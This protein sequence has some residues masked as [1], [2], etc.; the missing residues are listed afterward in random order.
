MFCCFSSGSLQSGKGEKKKKGKEKKE[1]RPDFNK[2]KKERKLSKK[3]GH[4]Y[5][6][7]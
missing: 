1:R 6:N 3:E 7:L 4:S 5:V 2:A